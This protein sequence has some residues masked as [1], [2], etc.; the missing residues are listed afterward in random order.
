MTGVHWIATWANWSGEPR[1][2]A[3]IL[4]LACRPR[5][6]KLFGRVCCLL[7]QRARLQ[8]THSAFAATGDVETGLLGLSLEEGRSAAPANHTPKQARSAPPN[9]AR[10]RCFEIAAFV[11]RAVGPAACSWLSGGRRRVFL[12]SKRCPCARRQQLRGAQVFLGGR[13]AA[14]PGARL[15]SFHPAGSVF[16]SLEG[17][18]EL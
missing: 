16:L 5:S 8:A 14:R 9:R 12:G 11:L 1:V 2:G 18:G 10:N 15:K 6:A 17:P 4:Q 13:S 7:C 3:P